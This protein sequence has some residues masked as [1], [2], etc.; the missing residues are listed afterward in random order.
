VTCPVLA[1]WGTTG[2]V[3]PFF[4]VLEIWVEEKPDETLRELLAFLG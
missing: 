3:A 2:N 1:L 4:D